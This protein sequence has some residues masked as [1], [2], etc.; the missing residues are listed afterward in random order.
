VQAAQHRRP[1]AVDR[2]PPLSG[3]RCAAALAAHIVDDMAFDDNA[4]E[5]A[6][7]FGDLAVR[8]EEQSDAESTLQAIVHSSVDLV[9]GARWAGISMIDGRQVRPRVPT[10]PLVA[11]LD[12]LQT[13]LDEGPCLDALRE[14]HTVAIDDMTAETR[15][16]RFAQAAA[17]RGVRS[18]L[19]FQLFVHSG[20]LG[21]LNLYGGETNVFDDDSAL[22]GIV[23]AQHAS[24][25]LAGANA[26]SQFH[27][28]LDSRDVIG[29]AKGLLMQ[30]NGVTGL[31]AFKMLARASQDTHSKLVDVARWLVDTHE[32]GLDQG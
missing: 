3:A 4:D 20:T 13:A 27:R 24:V 23:L 8:L 19:S 5:L 26:E 15:W 22:M 29:Q 18:L 10:D 12:G 31:H 21:A 25:A 32:S 16:P 9:P 14:H 6:R 11:E 1:V 7:I 2:Y 17:E 30:R 28:A